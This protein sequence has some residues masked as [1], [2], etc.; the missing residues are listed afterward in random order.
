MDRP[1]SPIHI[2][3]RSSKI[4]YR[5]EMME[6]PE[7]VEERSINQ[8]NSTMST[9]ITSLPPLTIEQHRK[10]LDLVANGKGEEWVLSPDQNSFHKW[11]SGEW[12]LNRLDGVGTIHDDT[13]GQIVFRGHFVSGKRSGFGRQFS[14]S[15]G[16]HHLKLH[17]F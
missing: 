3:A 14:T 6:R 12:K 4:L 17:H 16:I 9:K 1:Q 15:K 2:R 7:I 8:R 11:Y 10:Q 13:N 5:G